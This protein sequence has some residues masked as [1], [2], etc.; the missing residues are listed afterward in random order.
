[1]LCYVLFCFSPRSGITPMIQALHAILGSDNDDDTDA[2]PVDTNKK[3]K[4]RN[5]K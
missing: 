1:M 2:V 5:R 3:K 4:K